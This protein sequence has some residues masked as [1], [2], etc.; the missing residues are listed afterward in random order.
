[1]FVSIL[2]IKKARKINVLYFTWHELPQYC[3]IRHEVQIFNLPLEKH[4]SQH[5]TEGAQT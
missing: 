2:E 1:M 5:E 4:P 3:V